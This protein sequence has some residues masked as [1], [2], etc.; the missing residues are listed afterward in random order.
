MSKEK[1]T[2][3]LTRSLWS[4]EAGAMVE[5]EFY[6]TIDLS[7]LP[8][9]LFQRARLGKTGKASVAFGSIDVMFPKESN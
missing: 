5:F 3:R 6:V 9:K 1:M 8:A 4:A 7:K 2:K